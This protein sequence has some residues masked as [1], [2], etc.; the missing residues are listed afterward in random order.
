MTIVAPWW[1]LVAVVVGVFSA[2]WLSAL[3]WCAYGYRR[4]RPK[5][6]GRH[7]AGRAMVAALRTTPEERA[8]YEA[9]Q[10]ALQTWTVDLD[11]PSGL[12]NRAQIVRGYIRD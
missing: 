11:E 7:S 9:E 1:E 4:P 2:G 10:A 6:P 12:Y 8:E 5:S 3:L